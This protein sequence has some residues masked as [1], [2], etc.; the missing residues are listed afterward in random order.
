MKKLLIGLIM[1]LNLMFFLSGCVVPIEAG[2][3]V[4]LE[5]MRFS[6]D[7]AFVVGLTVPQIV[8]RFGPAP[9]IE[10]AG[11]HIPLVYNNKILGEVTG[12]QLE[13]AV[14][15]NA[16]MSTRNICVLNGIA[17]IDDLET[18]ILKG[19]GLVR[20]TSG[21]MDP[22]LAALIVLN[23]DKTKE[24]LKKFK[25]IPQGKRLEI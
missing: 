13:Y 18:V 11:C 25:D 23:D 6:M 8:T 2:N 1:S 5:D 17:V 19:T 14:R 24:F 21:F 7:S 4:K 3:I 20:Y 22:G 9:N 16:S 15:N 12:N 10:V